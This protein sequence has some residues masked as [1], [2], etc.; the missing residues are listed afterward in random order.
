MYVCVYGCPLVIL[1]V[2]VAQ[3][4]SET[5]AALL[6]EEGNER[7]AVATVAVIKLI[8]MC[9]YIYIYNI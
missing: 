3:P 6:D 9:T 7:L 8:I 4:P 2:Q 5:R 1:R